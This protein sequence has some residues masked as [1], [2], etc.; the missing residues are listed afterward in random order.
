MRILHKHIKNIC[1]IQLQPFGDVFLT[2]SYFR[3][4]KAFFPGARLTYLMKEPYQKIVK[5]HP[6]I[7]R[8]I[9]IKKARGFRYVLERLK[10]FRLL[11]R[12]AFD[13]VIDQQNMPSSQVLAFVSGAPYRLGY[14]SGRKNLDFLYNVHAVFGPTR[15]SAQ[16]KFD[17]VKPLGMPESPCH[18]VLP[19]SETDQRDMDAWLK[20]RNLVPEKTLAISPGS[21]FP[22][23]KWPAA[24][25]AQVADLL[26]EACGFRTV[27]LW[28]PGE[29]DDA[30]LVQSLMKSEAVTA[31]ATTFQQAGAIMKKSAV[32]VCNDNGIS[33]SAAAFGVKTVTVFGPTDPLCWSPSEVYKTHRHLHNPSAAKTDENFGITPF[34]VFDKV[35]ELLNIPAL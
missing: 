35:R 23:K 26:A 1:V 29:E 20:A 25:Y 12:E 15:Y 6:F 21:R 17:I 14:K 28:G 18:L 22:F 4:L 33:H 34:M 13:L 7:D 5:D 11:R 2:T 19:V 32:L 16:Q 30:R 3:A 10:T 24:A 8:I 31:P 27:I 9:T